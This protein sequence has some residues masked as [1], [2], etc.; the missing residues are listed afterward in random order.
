MK[1]IC[2][3]PAAYGYLYNSLIRLYGMHAVNAACLTYMLYTANMDSCT[4]RF[5]RCFYPEVDPITFAFIIRR[6]GRSY[7][8]EVQFYKAVQALLRSINRG[9]LTSPQINTVQ[10]LKGVERQIERH[11]CRVYGVDIEDDVTV[12]RLCRA[13][14]IPDKNEPDRPFAVIRKSSLS[15][16]RSCNI[17][18]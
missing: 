8:T 16:K 1:M 10:I 17:N 12:Y 3:T 4:V 13:H 11:F 7:R 18:Q 15:N 2:F 6:N 9:C 14:L 5:G